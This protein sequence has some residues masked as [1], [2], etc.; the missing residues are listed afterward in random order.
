VRS[1]TS[2][3]NDIDLERLEHAI[4]AALDPLL[5]GWLG[6]G[7]TRADQSVDP[8]RQADE[9]HKTAQVAAVLL[10]IIAGAATLAAGKAV[11]DLGLKAAGTALDTAGIVASVAKLV[12]SGAAYEAAQARHALAAAA[13]ARERLVVRQE[14]LD[15]LKRWAVGVSIQAATFT[16]NAARE[17]AISAAVQVEDHTPYAIARTWKTRGDAKVR[18]AHA[19]VEGQKRPLGE[20]FDVAGVPM[21]WPGDTLAPPELAANCRCR[22]RYSLTKG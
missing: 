7:S 3:T 10:P 12:G 21:R 1:G 11:A 17:A 5:E 13:S 19:A 6:A 2:E 18:P 20:P 4:A 22:L 15:M 8:S 16:Q 9:K 14:R